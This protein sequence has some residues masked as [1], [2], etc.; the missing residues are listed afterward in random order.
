MRALRIL[1]GIALHEAF[2]LL[3]SKERLL[4]NLYFIVT[5]ER[6]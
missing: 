6:G 1:L 3:Y 5:V 2:L 4:A